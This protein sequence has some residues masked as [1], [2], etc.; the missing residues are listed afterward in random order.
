MITT[1]VLKDFLAAG[2]YS[3]LRNAL[4][5]TIAV[6]S[7][8]DALNEALRFHEWAV[9]DE[10]VEDNPLF[11]DGHFT[12]GL[13]GPTSRVGLGLRVIDLSE[14][15]PSQQRQLALMLRGLLTTE[16]SLQYNSDLGFEDNLIIR[17]K[18]NMISLVASGIEARL[19]SGSAQEVGQAMPFF[20]QAGASAADQQDASVVS[21]RTPASE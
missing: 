4:E 6:D 5:R 12:P 20:Q 1:Q 10:D 7:V 8:Q 14:F 3:V 15:Q 18:A 11:A 17:E 9:V 13:L 19:E 16:A 21:D 2:D